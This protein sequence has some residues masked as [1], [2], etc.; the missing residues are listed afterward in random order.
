MSLNAHV[1]GYQGLEQDDFGERDLHI[2]LYADHGS[3]A[4]PMAPYPPTPQP[5]GSTAY[6]R[7]PFFAIVFLIHVVLIALAAI[8]KGIPAVGQG[9]VPEVE[10]D[11]ETGGETDVISG[12]DPMPLVLGIT[13]ILVLSSFV[14]T[15][16]VKVLVHYGESLIRCAL[17]STVVWFVI[18]GVSFVLMNVFIAGLIMLGMAG[19]TYLYYHAIGPRIEFAGKNLKV[20]C[21]A[22]SHMPSTIT[23]AVGLLA[24]QALW[25]MTWSLALLGVATSFPETSITSLD[26]TTTYDLDSCVT[27]ITDAPNASFSAA[28]ALAPEQS[29]CM[30]CSCGGVEVY[31]DMPCET[32]TVSAGVYIVMLFSLLWGCSVI[33]NIAHATTSGAIASWWFT[34]PD[35]ISGTSYSPVMAS[36]RRAAAPSLGTMALFGLFSAI[37]WLLRIIVSGLHRQRRGLGALGLALLECLIRAAEAIIKT[38]NRFALVYSA[39]YGTDA[40]QAGRATADLFSKRGWSAII[41]DQLIE[42]ALAMSCLVVAVLC[43]LGGVIIGGLLGMT[44]VLMALLATVGL[45]TGYSMASVTAGVVSSAIATVYVCFAEDHQALA[46]SHPPLWR[47]L[48]ASW[49]K[50][51]PSVMEICGYAQAYETVQREEGQHQQGGWGERR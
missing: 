39:I 21:T 46:Q 13:L 38:F 16:M 6:Y 49:T 27:Y 17:L 19:L 18:M 41:N 36:F 43:A 28:C 20:A 50:A 9:A 24:I 5:L 42:N 12:D 10:V 33:S 47:Q 3:S 2:P 44:H 15:V 37:A 51:H 26:G 4:P 34:T 1:G 35:S 23:A 7:D 30:K 32:H 8:L 48:M 22:I 40:R 11:S 14:S 45:F 29:T 25:C 31:P